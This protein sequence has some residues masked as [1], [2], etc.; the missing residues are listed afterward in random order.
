M[1]FNRLSFKL[2]VKSYLTSHLVFCKS[3]QNQCV[4]KL[5]PTFGNIEY[6]VCNKF[7][8]TCN[9]SHTLRSRK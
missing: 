2:K 3:G 6:L 9:Y 5:I 8:I 1:L 7:V 4:T